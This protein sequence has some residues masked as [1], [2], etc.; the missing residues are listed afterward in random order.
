MPRVV[1]DLSAD[2]LGLVLKFLPDAEDIARA[3]TVCHQFKVGAQRAAEARAAEAPVPLPPLKPGESKLRA[4]RWAETVAGRTCTISVGALHVLCAAPRDGALVS[5]GGGPS[6]HG[7]AF[8]DDQRHQPKAVSDLRP[9]DLCVGPDV[10]DVHSLVLDSDGEVWSWGGNDY[11]QLGRGDEEDRERPERIASLVGTR[12]LQVAA[13]SVHSLL[14]TGA[15]VVLAC[16]DNWAFQLGLGDDQA[17][18]RPRSKFEPVTGFA[19]RRAV[20]VSAGF[21]HS[22]AVDEA[23]GLWTWGSGHHGRLGHGDEE[24]SGSP[25]RVS[26][27]QRV[28]H[29]SLGEGHSL[30]VTAD[31]ALY[32]WGFDENGRLGLGDLNENGRL[33]DSWDDLALSPRLVTDLVG[34]AVRQA[35]AGRDFSVVLTEA[36]EVYTMGSGR[37][38]RLGLRDAHD[39]VV[40]T[41]VEALPRVVEVSA[42]Y[43]VVLARTASGEIFSWGFGGDLCLGYHLDDGST[44][45]NSPKV[46]EADALA[47]R[48]P[49][50]PEKKPLTRT[51]MAD[52]Y[53]FM[54]GKDPPAS[55]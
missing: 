38:G 6:G 12:I 16:G 50:M 48:R 49:T 54:F 22:A 44:S 25:H 27:S 51:S 37:N 33:G 7:W 9:R 24:A 19:D 21:L 34:K 17:A 14:L 10:D 30:A 4:L 26:L 13:G 41:L 42:G 8:D 40:P 20:E 43:D 5:W 18:R 39:R 28:R 32:A 31:G 47:P 45:R 11:G 53:A 36:G 35:S 15:G 55:V 2:E 52:V 29:A 46:I 3:A 1:L 23:G